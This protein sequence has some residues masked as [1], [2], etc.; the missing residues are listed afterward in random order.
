MSH[1]SSE[2]LEKITIETIRQRKGSSE[3]ITSLTAYDY[4]TARIMDEAGI[5]LILIGDSLANTVLGYEHTL[6]VTLDEMIH[7]SRAVRRAVKRALL[8]GDMPFGSYHAGIDSALAAAV[9]YVKEGGVEA[10][11]IEGG[12][13]RAELI[14][15][16][17]DSEIPVLGHIGLTPQSIHKM[18]G[19]KVQGKT[20]DTAQALIAD[21]L[22]LE[23][24]GAFA[25]VVEGIPREIAKLITDKVSIP[26]IGIGAG[27]ECDGQILVINDL[28][29]LSFGKRAK[30]VREYVNV[31]ELMT[32]AVKQYMSDVQRGDFPNETESYHLSHEVAGKLRKARMGKIA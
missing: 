14:R 26:T 21:A 17:V 25:I 1:T 19:Y 18:G 31:K 8:V 32:E 15:Q 22:A 3:R 11:K 6:P 13:K 16:L 10:V 12:T 27:V 5:D 29:G 4:P 24:A 7:H 20:V 23:S 9:R 2:L 28:V 30:F